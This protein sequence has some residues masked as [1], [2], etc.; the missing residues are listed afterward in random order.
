[1]VIWTI[2]YAS[3]CQSHLKALAIFCHQHGFDRIGWS[4]VGVFMIVTVWE[5]WSQNHY[6]SDVSS[7]VGDFFSVKH[8]STTLQIDLQHPSL[9][10]IDSLRFI[11]SR[12]LCTEII[13]LYSDGIFAVLFIIKENY[14]VWAVLR[15][16]ILERTTS[17]CS[18]LRPNSQ[19]W[20]HRKSVNP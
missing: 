5:Y 12:D 4:D 9:T 3:I 11:K 10:S 14:A 8:L 20:H 7:S 16:L 19:L 13:L 6:V 1:M 15:T 18:S 2:L 17:Q